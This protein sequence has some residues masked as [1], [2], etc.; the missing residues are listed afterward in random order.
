M[1]VALGRDYRSDAPREV[2]YDDEPPPIARPATVDAEP[3]E[4]PETA[5]P[6]APDPFAAPGRRI[7]F[8]PTKKRRPR[9]LWVG[10]ATAVVILFGGGGVLFALADG[11]GGEDPG[12]LPSAGGTVAAAAPTTPPV[13]PGLEPPRP[14][15]WPDKWPVFAR[16]TRSVRSTSTVSASR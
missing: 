14:G 7:A 8:S 11:G 2:S 4:S 9:A 10:I 12:P 3:T 5:E 1:F 6:P 15:D 13:Q 16:P